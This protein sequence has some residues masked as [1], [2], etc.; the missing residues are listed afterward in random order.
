MI[1]VLANTAAS[2]SGADGDS[3]AHD[4]ILSAEVSLATPPVRTVSAL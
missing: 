1:A 2:R 3:E 4:S